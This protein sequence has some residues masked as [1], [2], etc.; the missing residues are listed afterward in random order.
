MSLTVVKVHVSA[1]GCHFA[2]L[3]SD[4]RL[5]VVSNFEK[6]SHDEELY[7]QTL[8]VLISPHGLIGM[9]SIYLAFDYG[10]ISAVTVSNVIS[11]LLSLKRSFV[12]L[13]QWVSSSLN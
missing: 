1:C 6:V 4:H 7:A 11:D 10:R 2:A 12:R 3:L 8:D 13:R 5:L 9:G